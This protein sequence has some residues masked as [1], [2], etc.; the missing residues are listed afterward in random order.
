MKAKTYFTLLLLFLSLF[1]SA[2]VLVVEGKYQNKNLYVQNGFASNGIGFC[3]YEV[4]VNEQVTT[5]EINSSAFEIDFT[6]F[7]LK[8]GTPVIVKIKYRDDGCSPKV[9]NPDVLKARATFEIQ[10]MNVDAK[11]MLKWTTSEETTPLPFI[12]EQYRWN[13]W[14]KVGEVQGKG[15]LAKN[16]YNFQVVLTSA[17]NKFRVKQVGYG[18]IPKISA[19]VS[20]Y[21]AFNPPTYTIEKGKQINFSNET[22]FEIYDVY[23][24]LIKQGFG[25]KLAIDNLKKGNYY[26]CYDNITTD[27]KRK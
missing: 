8:F 5:D 26:L 1:S 21:S 17:E 11:G 3:T 27:F 9:I 16:N 25:K 10:E 15:Q 19:A 2:G 13:K 20:V 14:I 18:K 24:E 4:T 23:G 7:Q 12:V 22:L 6:P